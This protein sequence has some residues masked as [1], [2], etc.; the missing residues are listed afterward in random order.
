MLKIATVKTRERLL[1]IGA[2]AVLLLNAA[3][4]ELLLIEV[5]TERA[6]LLQSA[7]KAER[8]ALQNFKV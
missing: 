2:G 8:A 3:G 7:K 5:Y 6:A 4:A 1:S